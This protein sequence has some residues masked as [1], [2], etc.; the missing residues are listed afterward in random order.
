MW[1][2]LFLQPFTLLVLQETSPGTALPWVLCFTHPASPQNVSFPTRKSQ[3]QSQGDA[4]LIRRGS[5]QVLGL[6]ERA[7]VM[8]PWLWAVTTPWEPPELGRECNSK[9]SLM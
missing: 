6:L 7:S 5:C 4:V 3:L 8:L 2:E 1:L 9:V